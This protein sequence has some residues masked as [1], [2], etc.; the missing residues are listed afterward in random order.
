MSEKKK[1]FRDLWVKPKDSETNQNSSS[2][3]V[4]PGSQTT[5][6]IGAVGGEFVAQQPKSTTS[7]ELVEKF[8]TLFRQGI[9]EKDLLGV[10]MME[11]IRALFPPNTTSAPTSENYQ[12]IFD[13]F[14][15][16]DPSLTKQRLL[17]SSA[18]YR[19]EV[20][21]ETEKYLSEGKKKLSEIEETKSN[22]RKSLEKQQT[23]LQ[24]EEQKLREKIVEL[25]EDLKNNGKSQG[26]VVTNLS[27]IDRKYQPEL[28]EVKQKISAIEQA[29]ERV[30]NSFSDLEIGVEKYIVES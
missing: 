18:Y 15:V 3:E 30:V 27:S 2:S 14:K 7:T 4:Q 16:A 8:V 17:D 13:V 24:L 20:V 11:F 9:E 6:S 22:E 21:I 29:S 10:D 19:G 12:K 26:E 28:N 23:D 5:H 1:K 25:E